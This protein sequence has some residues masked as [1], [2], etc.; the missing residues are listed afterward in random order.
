MKRFLS[1][2]KPYWFLFSLA[3]GSLLLASLF[4][5]GM[6]GL[7]TSLTDNVLT[8]K[9]TVTESKVE[10]VFGFREKLE[11]FQTFLEG[12]GIPVGSI[13]EA[14]RLDPL[15]PLSWSIFVF[16]VFIGQALFNFIG[17]YTMGR[18]GLLVVV[19]LRQSL[20][21]RV[22]SLS[23][24]FF[25]HMNTGEILTRI[26]TDVLRIQQAISVKLGD[27]IKELA[28]FVVFTSFAFILDWK[29][30]LA[31][32]LLVPLA[33]YPIAVFTRKIKKNAVRSQTHLGGLTARFKE[34]LVGI[35]IVKGF[36]RESF[37]SETLRERNQAFLKY[38][39]RELANV[40]LTAPVMSLIGMIF[41]LSFLYYG[42][43]GIQSG[44]KTM[45]D[46]LFFLLVVY[47][48]F[49]PIK[50]V[51]RANSE[52]QQAIG[53]MPRIEEILSWENEIAEPARPQRFEAYPTIKRLDL[54]KV[55]FHY[56]NEEGHKVPVLNEVDLGL[57]AGSMIALVGASGAG[58]STLVNLIP[59][60]YDVSEGA[61]KING[62]DIRE[63]AKS[64]LRSLIGIVTQDTILFDDTVHNN[65]AY[66]LKDVSRDQVV[67]AAE[68]AFADTFIRNL[69]RGYDTAIGEAGNI[70]SG[71]QRQ[72]LSI[73]RAILKDAPILLLDEATSALDTES[74]RE[75]QLALDN[76]IKTKNNDRD[77]PPSLNHSS[78]T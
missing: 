67:H 22:L 16:I 14:G 60:F 46:F 47:Q 68:Q 56:A 63:M 61:I 72:R 41:L 15:N 45:G 1:L 43:L 59:R 57:E 19:G 6:T 4:N 52:I 54:E 34:V 17:T 44:E 13:K 2:I 53:V 55:C 42:A 64:D 9:V 25:K 40:A 30:S 29:A 75:V 5:A 36:R 7:V 65:I 8:E 77:R 20:I 62:L 11:N 49:Q 50:R 10:K 76:L 70:L 58:K 12:L 48:L 27:V 73:A 31:I 71:G 28:N 39:L 33:G 24:D 21:D 35:R 37:E 26:N 78:G 3:L 23:L 18:I 32:F 66:G 38:A 51:A 69:P 74:E